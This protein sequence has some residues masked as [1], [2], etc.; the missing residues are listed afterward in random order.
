MIDFVMFL[1]PTHLHLRDLVQWGK[2][3][4]LLIQFDFGK[5]T[6]K[7]IYCTMI[8]LLVAKPT[9]Q[10]FFDLL[11]LIYLYNDINDYFL[12]SDNIFYL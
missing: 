8:L 7:P 11:N 2:F 10:V 6:K 1:G 9:F 12:V 3:S 5:S 4:S